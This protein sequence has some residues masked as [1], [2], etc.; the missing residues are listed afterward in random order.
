MTQVQIAYLSPVCC[1]VSLAMLS[2]W[3]ILVQVGRAAGQGG[4]W[5][6]ASGHTALHL[7]ALCSLLQCCHTHWLHFTAKRS[8]SDT[9]LGDISVHFT[10][11][12]DVVSHDGNLF[13]SRH[14][15]VSGLLWADLS[16]EFSSFLYSLR[17][18]VTVGRLQAAL[19]RTLLSHVHVFEWLDSGVALGPLVEFLV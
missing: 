15:P 4:A 11:T 9:A 18:P 12:C 13:C 3:N 14:D 19:A 17:L 1:N 6:S 5:S 8:L 2:H 10:C 7:R 16:D